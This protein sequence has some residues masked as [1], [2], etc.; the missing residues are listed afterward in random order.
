MIDKALLDE[1]RDFMDQNSEAYIALLKSIRQ[2]AEKA[3]NQL[4][5]E[6]VRDIY[7]RGAKQDGNE[8]KHQP[9]I[10]EKLS[11]MRNSRR[12]FQIHEINDIIGL[13]VTVAY[14]ED[15]EHFIE[16]LK[17][18]LPNDIKITKRTIKSER[19]YYATH[20]NLTGATGEH[21]ALTCEVQVKT[22]LHDLWGAKT[23]D[24]T[25]KPGGSLDPRLG[26]L[27]TIAGDM[28]Q[29]VELQSSEIRRL[30]LADIDMERET[31]DAA[32][33]YLMDIESICNKRK[34]N[35][36]LAAFSGELAEAE[37]YI[38]H[39]VEYD[40]TLEKLVGTVSRLCRDKFEIGWLAAFD[41]ASKRPSDRLVRLASRNIIA[42]QRR[43]SGRLRTEDEEAANT[44]VHAVMALYALGNLD[45]AIEL[46]YSTAEITE[47][48]SRH[49]QMILHNLADYLVEREY[50][51]PT[52]DSQRRKRQLK[53]ILRL[54]DNS[55][56][57][58][59]E[60]DGSSDG[61]LQLTFSD[62]PK[63]IRA[64]IQ[65]CQDVVQHA[66]KGEEHIA[67]KYSELYIRL[68]WRKLFRVTQYRG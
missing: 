22:G 11:R 44:L 6:V 16:V 9:R 45:G 8:F 56:T 67:Q 27:M 2:H 36:D 46:S 26:T 61:F 60:I 64:A 34:N 33:M 41:L 42:F 25:Y 55:R 5:G 50:Y 63:V 51:K 35:P 32:R 62:D 68:G 39:C 37:H 31:R 65:K 29:A 59:L 13:T 17:N 23:H 4:G 3:K 15:I 52:T 21:A 66:Q 43:I 38:K 20:V 18:V 40:D 48:P 24:L 54:H 57:D 12:P 58:D 7:S 14:H 28:L 47:L 10:A 53:E 19:G 30:I 1:V 49:R